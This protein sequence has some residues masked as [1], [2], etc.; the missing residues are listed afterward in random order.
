MEPRTAPVSASPGAVETLYL[1]RLNDIRAYPGLYGGAI[2]VDLSDVRPA[3]PLA[4]D[5]T[6]VF[7]ARRHSQDM[8]DRNY[9]DRTTPEGVGFLQRITS[10]G[11][12]FQS[13][14]ESISEGGGLV[15]KVVFDRGTIRLVPTLVSYKPDDSLQDLVNDTDQ[16]DLRDQNLLLGLDAVARQQRLVGIGFVDGGT[17]GTGYTLDMTNPISKDPY[18]T[19][20]VF[21]DV[22]G[23][24]RYELG[25][26]LGGVHL[27][28]RRG[29]KVV[30]KIVTWDGGGY[31]FQAKPGKYRVTASGGPLAA[32]VT[33]T[34]TVG[35]DNARLEFILP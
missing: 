4:F 25:E 15:S 26:G 23:T 21:R 17:A 1:E 3:A 24:G 11:L 2:G 35:A 16:P 7:V 27:Q 8:L 6:L 12:L 30:G 10:A 9:F 5:P 14:A 19:G 31:S 32:P 28:F 34:V 22:N 13:A 29:G 33:E 18:I 20:A